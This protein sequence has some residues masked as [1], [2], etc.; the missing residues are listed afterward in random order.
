MDVEE[1]PYG[2]RI[3]EVALR[4]PDATAVTF[5]AADGG[6]TDITWR[7]LDDRA[8]Q[9]A[10][11]LR[12]DGLGPGDLLAIRLRNS[13]EFV[14]SAFAAWKVGAV[15]I[16]MRWDLPEWERERLLE[17][18]SA[19]V[20]LSEDSAELF[21][22]SL[23]ASTE[24]LPDV[25]SPHHSGICSSGSTGTPKVILRQA[26]A[27]YT[28]ASASSLVVVEEWGALPRPQLVLTPGPMYHNN[29][30]HITS[31][32][33]AG[34]NVVLMERFDA[35]RL[36][37]LV[38]QLRITGM[39]GATPMYQRVA[40]LPDVRSRDFSSIQWVM[41]GASLLPPWVAHVWFDLIGP[42]RFFM[43]YAA[44]EGVG[45][46]ACRG[47]EWLAHPGTLG[48]GWRG[49]QVRILGPDK[50]QLPPGEIGD[51]YLRPPAGIRYTYLGAERTADVTSEGFTTVGDMGWMDDDAF[52]YLADRRVDMIV[53]GGSNV[54]PAEVEVAL[55]EHPGVADVVVIGLPDETWGK[56][57][58][59]IVQRSDSASDLTEADVISFGRDRLASYKLPKSVEFVDLIPRAASTK[60]SRSALV[61]ERSDGGVD[62]V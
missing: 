29:G 36:V 53:T 45:T 46:I 27:I 16:P 59:A 1:V 19:K 44:S 56:R 24:Q 4:N 22:R 50:Q 9:V 21:A 39:T 58:H 51:I 37:D 23:Q 34:L 18:V 43:A 47:D 30:F 25:V 61:A 2:R 11:T 14:Y 62:R 13:P 5:A 49:V 33:L 60:V 48:R 15:P 8:T 26:P 55:S 57:V 54:F 35:A 42:E 17:V 52:V 31:D 3:H 41:Q 12:Q 7:M 20:V 38:E 6:L 32:L 28:P 10:H 40:Q